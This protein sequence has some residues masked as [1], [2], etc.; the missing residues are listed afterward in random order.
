MRLAGLPAGRADA[1]GTATVGWWEVVGLRNP[2]AGAMGAAA[3]SEA[4][5]LAVP[6]VT[7]GAR[8]SSLSASLGR[9]LLSLGCRVQ[10]VYP[11]P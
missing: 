2:K 6:A 10:L 8:R 11:Q 7:R 5:R 9:A 1:C 3:A 4:P